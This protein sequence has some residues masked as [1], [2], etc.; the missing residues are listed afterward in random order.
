MSMCINGAIRRR[1]IKTTLHGLRSTFV[2]MGYLLGADEK[3][4]TEAAGHHSVE[5]NR[6]RYQSVYDSMKADLANKID[7]ALYAEE[8]EDNEE[9]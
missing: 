7:K 3:A 6:E 5:F 8:E 2:S 1:G 4:I 9:E